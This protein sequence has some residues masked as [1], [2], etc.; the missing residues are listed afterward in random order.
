VNL[1]IDVERVHAM[2]EGQVRKGRT[3]VEAAGEVRW[4]VGLNRD[5]SLASDQTHDETMQV[6]DQ[7]L[8]TQ[9]SVS[10]DELSPFT[11]AAEEYA[12]F[13]AEHVNIDVAV[14][15]ITVTENAW[16]EWR[17]KTGGG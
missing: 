6:I 10:M 13:L 15:P 8:A 12:R 3:A 11:L 9:M 1:S 7:W 16:R 2:L 4:V 17:E 5:R 14:D